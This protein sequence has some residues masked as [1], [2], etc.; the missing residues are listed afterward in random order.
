MSLALVVKLFQSI[1]AAAIDHYHFG[2]KLILT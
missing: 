1:G 2:W